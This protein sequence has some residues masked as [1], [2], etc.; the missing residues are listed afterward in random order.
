[1]KRARAL[2]TLLALA[3]VSCGDLFLAHEDPPDDPLSNFNQVWN[4]FD[5]LYAF[6][7]QKGIDWG[8]ARA[9]Y[10]AQVTSTTTPQELFQLLTQMLGD[11][12]DGHVDLVAPGVGE[13]GYDGWYRDR[14]ANFDEVTA[15]TYVTALRSAGDG[16]LQ[17]GRIDQNIG[18]IRIRSFAGSGWADDI[19][20]VIHNLA[21]TRGIIVDIRDNTGG[22]T[23]NSDLIASRFADRERLYAQVRYRN[24]P[25]HDDFTEWLMR[26]VR[27]GGRM[28][29]KAPVIVLT[30]R[31]V[32]SAAESFVLEMRSLPHVR[33]AGDTTGGGSGSPITRE[34]PNGWT[35]RVPRWQETP[36]DGRP[37]EGTGIVP[38]FNVQ[39]TKADAL[40]RRDTILEWAIGILR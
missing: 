4:D 16:N 24:G 9:E 18:Y 19:D 23:L 25:R 32:F 3:L 14:P 12:H 33:I 21:L 22:S 26:Y 17:Y 38:D 35:Y 40:H 2:L 11:L 13:W 28:Q 5:Q 1:M 29:F 31:R 8:Q 27:P 34:L 7:E 30:N 36:P 39:I 10:G 6:F 15:V 37:Y 20:M